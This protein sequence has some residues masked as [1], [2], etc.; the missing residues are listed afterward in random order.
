MDIDDL[1]HLIT[2][3]VIYIV[4][5]PLTLQVFRTAARAVVMVDVARMVYAVVVV[6]GVAMYSFFVF[7][8]LS[9]QLGKHLYASLQT[10]LKSNPHMLQ[11]YEKYKAELREQEEKERQMKELE[12][13]ANKIKEELAQMKRSKPKYIEVEGMN[14]VEDQ[15]YFRSSEDHDDLPA[16]D[17]GERHEEL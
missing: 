9:S 15:D 12:E 5:G 3:E 8:G 4:T 11:D 16:G 17:P 2:A 13:Q 14:E 10:E 1:R 7:R 6:A